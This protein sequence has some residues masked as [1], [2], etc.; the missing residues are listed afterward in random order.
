[1]TNP[2]EEALA[3]LRSDGADEVFCAVFAHNFSALKN[4]HSTYIREADITP[5]ADIQEA[6]LHH[7]HAS[8]EMAQQ[9]ALIK[10][11]GGLGTSMGLERAKSLL[12]VKDGLTFL[13][14]IIHQTQR[15]RKK[16]HAQFPLL[17]M[18]SFSTSADTLAHIKEHHSDFFNQAL[19]END[20][21]L[22]FIQHREPKLLADTLRP[23]YFPED[24]ALQ[25]CPPGH[26]DFY[27]AF[28]GSGA[29]KRLL[30]A[31]FKYAF[32]SNSDNLGATFDAQIANYF[33]ESGATILLELAKKTP[34]DVKGG[35]I[36]L[37][38]DGEG[39]AKMLLREV[40][41]IHSE[42][43]A[44]ALDPQRHP[45]FNTNSLWLNLEKL[46]AT[47]EHN[48]GVLA[49]PVIVN[50]KR[51]RPQDETTPKVLQLETAIGAAISVLDDTAVIGVDRQRFLPVKLNSDLEDLRSA[52][53]ALDDNFN[54]KKV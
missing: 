36:V 2:L 38:G 33:E 26:G 40:A 24:E 50:E 12:E 10:L 6:H 7:G 3:K 13:D 39:G 53:Y 14:V 11:N 27:A 28:Y 35:H 49:L 34:S 48:Q 31:G 29:M 43:T 42:D 25:W 52:K 16:Y 41:Q 54:L 17:F 5:L 46:Q 19:G 30:D 32:V 20:L 47:L 21:P 18:N 23:A 4:A 15:L 8:D 9:T 1:M 45:Y 44:A 37:R 22:E 51:L